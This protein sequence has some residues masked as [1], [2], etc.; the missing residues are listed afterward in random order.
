MH[1]NLTPHLDRFVLRRVKSGRYNNAS[2]V[3]REALRKLEDEELARN[4]QDL[5]DPDDAAALVQQGLD[6]ITRGEYVDINGEDELRSYFASLRERAR[7]EVA[8]KSGKAR[9]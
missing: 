1:V 5:Q 6:S 9:K 2:E 4:S 8:R 7:K 3:I